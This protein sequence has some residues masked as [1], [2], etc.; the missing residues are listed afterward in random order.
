MRFHR[1]WPSGQVRVEQ[2]VFEPVC[3]S[4]RTPSSTPMNS[5][6]VTLGPMRMFNAAIL[7]MVPHFWSPLL[8]SGLAHVHVCL[9]Y[10]ELP[11]GLFLGLGKLKV[12]D[13]MVRK[14]EPRNETVHHHKLDKT[15]RGFR[16]GCVQ[17]DLGSKLTKPSLFFSSRLGLQRFPSHCWSGLRPRL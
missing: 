3:A 8:V 17:E 13:S 11:P 6:P 4:T 5:P 10:R 2:I 7:L 12:H 9:P 1:H 15:V 16:R 14:L